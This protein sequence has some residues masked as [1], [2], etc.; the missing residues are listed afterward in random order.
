MLE[1]IKSYKINNVEYALLKWSFR[2]FE[3]YIVHI[4]STSIYSTP[5]EREFSTKEKALEYILN[6]VS[7]GWYISPL[8]LYFCK[9]FTRRVTANCFSV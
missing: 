7:K 5:H 1:T 4:Y 9:I 8:F 3:K 2:G 6:K